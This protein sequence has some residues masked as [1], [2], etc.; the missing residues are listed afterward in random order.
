MAKP[1][2]RLSDAEF[3][4]MMAD[5]E[6]FEAVIKSA[7]VIESEIEA[8]FDVAFMD[9][10]RLLKMELR[11]EQ[12]VH[13]LLA[14]GMDARFSSPLKSLANLRNRFAH[15]LDA[16]FSVSDADNFFTAFTKQDQKMVRDSYHGLRK[17][18]ETPFDMQ[19]PLDK[20]VLC[21]V[22]LR[23]ALVVATQSIA[24]FFQGWQSFNVTGGTSS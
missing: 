18:E 7:I 17:T 6:P 2:R 4:K 16:T 12:K 22:W 1:L 9:P 3:Y 20:F 8:F 21:V 19:D 10:A 5:A 11:Y 23:A 14:L 13:L 24:E 15:N